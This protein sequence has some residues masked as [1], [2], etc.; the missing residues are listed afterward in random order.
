VDRRAPAAEPHSEILELTPLIRRVVAARVRDPDTVDDLVQEALTRLIAARPRL[1][2]EALAP[3][4]I[5]TARNLVA[6]LA[7]EQERQRRH[8]HRLVD[9]T[10]PERPDEEALRREEAAAVD[11]ALA[12]L[13]ARD[14]DAVVAHEVEGV[15]TASLAGRHHSTPGA[16]AVQLAR[17]RARLRVDY[18][19]A[20]ERVELPTERCRP[21]L[22]A[23]SAGDRRRQQALDAGGHLLECRTCARLSKPLLERRR[24]VA[25][26]LPLALLWLIWKKVMAWARAHP[27][28]A[29]TTTAAV[30]SLA[31]AP[32][33]LQRPAPPPAP[34]PPVIAPVTTVAPPAPAPAPTTTPAPTTAPAPPPAPA[35]ASGP[36]TGATQG[37]GGVLTVPGGSLLPVPAGSGL[38]RWSGQ[39][40]TARGAPVAQVWADEGFWVGP[41]GSNRIWVQLVGRG[42]SPFW[43][44]PGQ[45]VSFIGRLVPNAPGYAQRAGLTEREG[46]KLLAGQTQHIEVRYESVRLS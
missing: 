36:K 27:V 22:L 41:G 4:A 32:L 5:V 31:A 38:A 45:K 21:V 15:D 7:R 43:V 44:R 40:V 23:L 28:Q 9:L 34:P 11:A 35:P 14:R 25:V 20:S 1:E 29:V 19:V 2:D 46:R 26:L 13:S 42:E 18:L 3:Y 6:S 39:P 30:A 16:I 17:A 10:E 37:P 33:L 8:S 12:R 24:P